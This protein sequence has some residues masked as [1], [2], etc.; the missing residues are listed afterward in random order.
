MYYDYDTVSRTIFTLFC[1]DIQKKSRRAPSR[2]GEDLVGSMC[3]RLFRLL[4][5]QPNLLA[6]LR[7]LGTLWSNVVE[8]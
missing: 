5:E 1:H 7:T 3:H 6:R 4:K 8:F 2:A